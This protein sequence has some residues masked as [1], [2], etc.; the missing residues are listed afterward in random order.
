MGHIYKLAYEL[1][2]KPGEFTADKHEK[3]GV[4]LTD[5]LLFFSIIY[6]EDGSLSSHFTS[7]D[8][9]T[10]QPMDDHEVFKVWTLLASR[11]ANSHTLGAGH[12]KFVSSVFE[13]IKQT[14]LVARDE[15]NSLP[16]AKN[17]VPPTSE[18]TV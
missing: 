18:P 8:G 9:R 2:Y 1:S 14:I 7:I 6:P 10:K 11:L 4:G 15:V 3:E 13:Q 17:E 16:E 5:A 12:K